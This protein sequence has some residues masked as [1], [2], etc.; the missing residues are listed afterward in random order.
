VCTPGDPLVAA[1]DASSTAGELRL[2]FE[3]EWLTADA[4]SHHAP[5]ATDEVEQGSFRLVGVYAPV[6]RLNVLAVV[7]IVR[8]E[9]RTT[10]AGHDEHSTETGLGDVELGARW[11]VLDR[12]EFGEMRRQWVALSAGTSMPTGADD[13]THDGELLDPHAQVGTGGWGPYAGVLYRLEQGDW[14][15]FASVTGR[16]RTESDR[17]YRFGGSV[18]WTV[19]AQRQLGHRVA[20]G[21][22]LDGRTAAQDEEGGEKVPNTGGLVL[23]ATPAIYA[24][25]Y[26]G[27]WISLRAQ[28]PFATDLLGEQTVG[29]VVVVGVQ[30]AVF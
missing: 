9:A 15:A 29:P 21:L 23:A 19:Q 5:G 13:A 1:S 6:D 18:H 7:P 8:K 24:D 22:A 10:G 14:G 11:F 17:G 12:M 4:G 20:L 25:V 30:R 26:R 16:Y 27:T 28:L 3:A 2:A